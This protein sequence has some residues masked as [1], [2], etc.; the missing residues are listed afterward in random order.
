LR[1]RLF[2]GYLAQAGWPH[3]H[4]ISASLE[5]ASLQNWLQYFS[6]PGGT[7]TQGRWAH[8]LDFVSV[9]MISHKLT[10]ARLGCGWLQSGLPSRR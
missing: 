3:P 2:L 6:P 1:P 4:A 8:F 9:I 10:V 7:Q 5:P